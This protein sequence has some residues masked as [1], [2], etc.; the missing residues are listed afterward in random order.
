MQNAS[1]AVLAL[2]DPNTMRRAAAIW[3]S[4][5]RR[6][7]A[8]GTVSVLGAYLSSS[9]ASTSSGAAR[10]TVGYVSDVEGDREAQNTPIMLSPH[11]SRLT[12]PLATS[13]G[14]AT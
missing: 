11:P 3:H 14:S 13:I 8:V 1:V 7:A 5:P 12:V 6:I 10:V 9:S 2:P 4:V